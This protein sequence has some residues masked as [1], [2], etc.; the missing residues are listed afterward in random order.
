MELQL[1]GRTAVVSGASKGIGLAIT[2]ALAD[3]GA[4]VV[5]GARSRTPELDELASSG[6]VD[7]V[8]L[9]LGEPEAPA[10]LVQAA[11]GRVDVLV[12]NVGL[13]RPRVGGFLSVTDDDWTTTFNL[14][15]LAAVRMCRA[16]LPIMLAAGRGV[17]VNTG[18]VNA[19]LPDPTVVDYSASKAALT[20]FAKSLSKEFGPQGIRVNTIAPGPVATDLWLGKDGVADTLSQAGGQTPES[21]QEA[22]VAGTAT[23]R[24]TRPAEVA[25]LVVFLAS[26]RAA[27]IT[28]ANLAIDGGLTDT[29]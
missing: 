19:M 17:I 26:D 29:L 1:S 7:V 18:S 10:R 5:A 13:A 20:N 2:R 8:L 4:H 24:F 14:N 3:E 6:R 22:A 16:A 23:R 27:N 12:N 25:D 28:G 21:I 15:L 11:G 9:D